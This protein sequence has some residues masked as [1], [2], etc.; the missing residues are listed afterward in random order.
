MTKEL[1]QLYQRKFGV[2]DVLIQFLN[3]DV[4]IR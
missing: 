4:I 1:S 2:P 3:Q